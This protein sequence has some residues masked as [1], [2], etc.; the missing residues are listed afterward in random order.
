ME[1]NKMTTKDGQR[2]G[3]AAVIAI[4]TLL[5]LSPLGCSAAKPPV[6]ASKVAQDAMMKKSTGAFVSVEH[7][8]TG[9]VSIVTEGTQRYLV[10]DQGFTTSEGPDLFVILHQSPNPKSYGKNSYVSLGKLQ[11]VAGMQRYAIPNNLDLK[12]FKT[13]VIWCRQFS[14]TFAYAP[15]S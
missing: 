4:I 11:A 13:A 8:T 12:S 14:A 6:Q 7:A 5:A 9:N 10:L 1:F 2:G 3:A 15:L